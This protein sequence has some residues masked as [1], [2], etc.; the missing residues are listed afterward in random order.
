LG[1]IEANYETPTPVRESLNP[2]RPA[3]LGLT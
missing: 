3:M 1:S 2:V